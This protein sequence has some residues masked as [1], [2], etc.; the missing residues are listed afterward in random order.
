MRVEILANRKRRRH[1]SPDDRT[2]IVAET[3]AAGAKVSEVARTRAIAPGCVAARG[4][5]RHLV[6]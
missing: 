3:M 6:S 1:W 4:L 2:R 5:I